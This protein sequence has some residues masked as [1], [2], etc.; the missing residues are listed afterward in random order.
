[1]VITGMGCVTSLGHTP[2][3]FY[4]NLLTGTSGISLIENFDTSG[5][6][7]GR[8]VAGWPVSLIIY[9]CYCLGQ[10]AHIDAWCMFACSGAGSAMNG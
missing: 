10:Q 7:K 9:Y 6:C 2:A 5:S 3:Q 4:N 1:M 8:E